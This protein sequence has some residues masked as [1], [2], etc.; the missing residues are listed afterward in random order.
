MLKN[1]VRFLI[2]KRVAAALKVHP[3]FCFYQTILHRYLLICSL[4]QV[5]LYLYGESTLHANYI[6]SVFSAIAAP[7]ILVTTTMPSLE[8]EFIAF[9]GGAEPLKTDLLPVSWW[10]PAIGC[11]KAAAHPPKSAQAYMTRSSYVPS[12]SGV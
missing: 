10:L 8:A 6:G 5:R 2:I 1:V 4:I 9:Q 11:C 3:Q 7:A 12:A